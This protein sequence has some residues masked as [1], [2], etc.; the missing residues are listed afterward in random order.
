MWVVGTGEE[1]GWGDE[2]CGVGCGGRWWCDVEG[3]CGGGMCVR[4]GRVGGGGEC[5]GVRGVWV[6][7]W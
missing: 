5:G 3:G 6:L 7:F 2:W 4:L 1:S